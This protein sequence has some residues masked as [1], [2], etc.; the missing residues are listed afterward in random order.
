MTHTPSLPTELWQD[1]A[2]YLEQKDQLP[3][4]LLNRSSQAI[5]SPVLYRRPIIKGPDERIGELHENLTRE[6]SQSKFILAG[7]ATS[8][9]LRRL[10]SGETRGWVRHCQIAGFRS[11]IPWISWNKDSD[12]ISPAFRAFQTLMWN[13]FTLVGSFPS[14]KSVE[15]LN[16]EIPS[17]SLYYICSRPHLSLSI[18]IVGVAFF[19]TNEVEPGTQFTVVRFN[20][21]V[22]QLRHVMHSFIIL[23]LGCSLRELALGTEADMHLRRFYQAHMDYAGVSLPRLELLTISWILTEY[24]PFFRATP[25]LIELRLRGMVK[26]ALGNG[27][28]DASLLPKLQRFYGHNC[29][30]PFFVTGRPIHTIDTRS[31]TGR[32]VLF[33]GQEDNIVLLNMMPRFGSTVDVR[34]LIWDNCNSNRAVLQYL[35]DCNPKINLLELTPTLPYTKVSHMFCSPHLS[36]GSRR[37]RRDYALAWMSLRS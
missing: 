12:Q 29:F 23:T 32:H 18:A 14:L 36:K 31:S 33:L 1:I 8:R 19:G 9:L 16:A 27:P 4:L 15:I 5:Y 22:S 28:L 2:S 30:V 34:N 21:E 35:V 26:M 25:N 24:L 20:S 6:E 10:E 3:L 37:C 11:Q 17:D 13:I 7:P